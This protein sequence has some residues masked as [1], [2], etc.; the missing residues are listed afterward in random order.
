MT[1]RVRT[2]VLPPQ[3]P[4]Q[5][6]ANQRR[7]KPVTP[8]VRSHDLDRFLFAQKAM[9][10]GEVLQSDGD[11]FSAFRFHIANPIGIATESIHNY[12]FGGWSPILNYFKNRLTTQ[13]RLSAD[14][15]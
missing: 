1:V 11:L 14:M 5:P 8:L 13:T 15:R 3:N 2:V 4:T 12:D 10:C 9:C 6:T 7:N